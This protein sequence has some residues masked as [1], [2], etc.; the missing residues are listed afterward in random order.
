MEQMKLF[1]EKEPYGTKTHWY[2]C[3]QAYIIKNEWIYIAFEF[4]KAKPKCKRRK[5]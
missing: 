2:R 4:M 5:R 3:G 1:E